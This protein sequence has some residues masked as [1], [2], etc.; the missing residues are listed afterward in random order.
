MKTAVLVP[1]HIYYSDQLARLD[2]CLE[3]LSSQTVV[4]H[5]FVSISFANDSYKQEFSSILR[6][7]LNV[8]FKLSTEQKFQMEHLKV[9]SSL[10][11][12]YDMLMF[13]DDDDTYLPIRVEK[14]VEAFESV[15]KH[16][17]NNAMLLGGVREVT[18]TDYENESPEYWAYGIPPSLLNEF[19]KRTEGYHELMRH[20]FADMY[21]RS[22]LKR[23]RAGSILFTTY[24]ADISGLT[25][26]Q[27]TIDNPNSIT[28][29]KIAQ[30]K[31][32]A[33]SADYA[34][35]IKSDLTLSLIC[36]RIDLVKKG[37]ELV[38]CPLRMLTR[39]VP[40]ANRIKELNAFLYK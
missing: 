30:G 25:M 3:S 39:L 8:K 11:G 10:V 26:Y 7:Y 14:F 37:L 21:L 33:T 4:P 6:K 34:A 29:T 27:Y 31:T 1:S 17:E 38:D 23:T 24:T 18:T 5:I 20:K 36:D 13:C 35:A 32:I 28:M 16:C 2:K 12:D 40:N 22:Y 15:K 19:F 9:L